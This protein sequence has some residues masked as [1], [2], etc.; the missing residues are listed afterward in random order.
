MTPDKEGS[1]LLCEALEKERR[2]INEQELRA[3]LKELLSMW[4]EVARMQMI[5]RSTHREAMV[6]YD[7]IRDLSEILD[8]NDSCIERIDSP[9]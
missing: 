8:G 7:C 6:R 4:G 3:K 9:T 2:M 1:K 5:D